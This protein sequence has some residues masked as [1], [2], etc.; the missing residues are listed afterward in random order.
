MLLLVT[1]LSSAGPM[2]RS[3]T[4]EIE[5]LTLLVIAADGF[6]SIDSKPAARESNELVQEEIRSLHRQLEAYQKSL[7]VVEERGNRT[8]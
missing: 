3:F 1:S 5:S 4:Q 7:L 2:A 6:R 8:R